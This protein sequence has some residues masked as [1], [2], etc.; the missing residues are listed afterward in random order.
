MTI[1]LYQNT[2]VA[3]KVD[4]ILHLQDTLQGTLRQGTSVL[5]PSF[6]IT[7]ANASLSFN[8]FKVE[9]WSRYYFMTSPKFYVNGSMTLNGVIDPLMSFSADIKAA[10][11]IIKRQEFLYNLYLND[12]RVMMNQNAKHK[13]VAFPN[14]FD[15]FSYILALAGNGQV[16]PE[17]DPGPQP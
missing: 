10:K 9:E 2:S 15:E 12:D 6:L 1:I 16:E 7:G 3:N 8:Y 4:K 11:G 5:A 14:S 17:P 13:I